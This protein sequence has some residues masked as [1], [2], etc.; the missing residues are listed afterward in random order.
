MAGYDHQS[1]R[2]ENTEELK[3]KLND[4]QTALDASTI[5]AITDARGV[6]LEV[7]QKFCEISGYDDHEL[8]GRTHRI[9]NSGYHPKAF[10]KEMW[11]TILQGEIWSGEIRN[12]A[13]DGRI[14]WTS[15]TIIPIRDTHHRIERF[16]AIRHDISDR[17]SAE[18]KLKQAL[19]DDYRIVIQHLQNG[20]FKLKQQPEG[21]YVFT[22]SEG[23]IAEKLKRTTDAV[24]GKTIY[25]I[26]DK[27]IA[28]RIDQAFRTALATG[29][30][31]FELDIQNRHYL[32]NIGIIRE[33]AGDVELAGSIVDITEQTRQARQI[34][35]MA[36]FDELTGLPN[37]RSFE[38]EVDRRKAAESD[39][40]Y[41]F[42]VLL[43]NLDRFQNINETLGHRV[44]DELLREIATR[45]EELLEEDDYLTRFTGD[46]FAIVMA[47]QERSKRDRE[48]LHYRCSVLVEYLSKAYIVRGMEIHT[49]ASIGVGLYPLHA[50]GTDELI[51]SAEAAISSAKEQGG[52]TFVLFDASIRNMLD[53]RILIEGELRKEASRD[54]FYLV[55]QAKVNAKTRK[56]CGFE[57]LLRWHHPIF[58]EL[59]PAEFIPVAEK[60]GLIISLGQWVLKHSIEQVRKWHQAGHVL[61]VSINISVQQFTQSDFADFV[62]EQINA[63]GVDPAMIEL[64]VTE[65]VTENPQL[66][67]TTMKK[68]KEIGVMISMDDFGT[69]YSSLGFLGGYPFDRIKIDKSFIIHLSEENCSVVRTIIQLA[70]NLNMT[71]T[72]EGV[73]T[74]SHADFLTREQCDELQGFFFSKPLPAR[75]TE[76]I[77]LKRSKK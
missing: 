21:S 20:V 44:G 76:R 2:A 51:Q 64:E 15:S 23:L 57:T 75:K 18:L 24:Y 49:T 12:K 16:I 52:N 3:K 40:D 60:S 11:D 69:G 63:S 1:D 47:C 68:L 41:E 70:K 66:T 33:E 35:K 56:L 74:E 71:V 6:I 31:R 22:M 28:T 32:V 67:R 48:Y 54:Q 26:F 17:V 25:E 19:E 42:A 55:Y 61:P 7:N 4:I 45:L 65:S 43:V 8:V 30:T 46:E 27:P 34:H 14:Y 13:K 37:R 59:S 72:A 9:L 73:E 39:G 50:Q 5:V 58:G 62:S 77:W 29:Q 36:Y 10:F 53:R 38:K